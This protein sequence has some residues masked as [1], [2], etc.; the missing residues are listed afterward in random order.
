MYQCINLGLPGFIRVLCAEM[1]NVHGSSHFV[2]P[3]LHVYMG[4]KGRIELFC[5]CGWPKV[6]T[7][8]HSCSMVE[9]SWVSDFVVGGIVIGSCASASQKA[10]ATSVSLRFTG[11]E[12]APV[13]SQTMVTFQAARYARPLA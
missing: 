11:R 10:R 9:N 1:R 13:T 5:G 4:C 6:G 8:G 3:L 7:G 2:G 12:L